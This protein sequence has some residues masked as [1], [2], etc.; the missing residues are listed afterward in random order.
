MRMTRFL[1]WLAVIFA[2]PVVAAIVMAAVGATLPREHAAT[3]HV[4]LKSATPAAVWARISDEATAPTWRK[5]LTR[6]VR[7]DDHNGHEVWGEEDTDGDTTAYETVEKRAP[8][9]I[10]REIAG[11]I[12]FGGQWRIEIAPAD[13][14]T[15]VTIT[16]NG[17]VDPPPIRFLA[18][19]VF[20][21]TSSMDTYLRDLAVS[22]G[23][24][25][26][27]IG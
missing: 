14:G 12:V 8:D 5:E 19:F 6:S 1:K 17:W 20:G 27:V 15:L 21:F 16:E 9:L 25:E 24:R 18:H 10:V 4:R 11:A 7:L 22:F 13:G 23:E 3:R 2:V 26:A